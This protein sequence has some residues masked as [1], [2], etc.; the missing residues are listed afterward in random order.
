MQVETGSVKTLQAPSYIPLDRRQIRPNHARHY[1][2]NYPSNHYNPTKRKRDSSSGSNGNAP[3]ARSVSPG[4]A[5]L[6]PWADPVYPYTK[7]IIGLHQEID[8]FY[9][10]IMPTPEEHYMRLGVVRR[11]EEC[12]QKLW[13]AATLHVFGS[14]KTGLYL[15]TSDIDLVLVGRWETLPLRT[16]ERALLDNK[17]ADPATLKVLDKA[18]VPIIKL[19]D[20]I[21]RVRVDVSFNMA[22]GLK[23]VELVK[24]YKKRYP[25]LAKLICVLKQF[26]LQRDLNEVF[27]GGLSSYCLILMVVSFL[28]LHPRQ[29]AASHSANLGVLLIEFFELYG[30]NFNYLR[31]AIRVVGDGSYVTKEQVQV[32]MPPG[33]RPSLLCIEDPLQPGND[34]GKSSY[35]ALQVRQSFD[36]AYGQLT[37]AL[38]GGSGPSILSRI[39]QVDQPTMEYR[40]WIKNT[41]PV[42]AERDGSFSPEPPVVEEKTTLSHELSSAF[43]TPEKDDTTDSSCPSSDVEPEL[44]VEDLTPRPPSADPTT[45]AM[46]IS[47]ANSEVGSRSISRLSGGSSNT[48]PP[49]HHPPSKPAFATP[50]SRQQTWPRRSQGNRADLD[51][52]WRASATGPASDRSSNSGGERDPPARR[53]AERADKDGKW[54]EENGGR[55]PSGAKSKKKNGSLDTSAKKEDISKKSDLRLSSHEVETSSGTSETS[56]RVSEASSRVSEASNRASETSSRVP[57]H[58][59]KVT[60]KAIPTSDQ[61]S[62]LGKKSRKTHSEKSDH[63]P[64]SKG[65][66]SPPV[67]T[68]KGSKP[69]TSSAQSGGDTPSSDGCDK[70]LIGRNVRTPDS[71]TTQNNNNTEPQK[72]EFSQVK[73]SKKKKKKRDHDTNSVASSK[74][75]SSD[76]SPKGDA[77]SHSAKNTASVKNASSRFSGVVGPRIPKR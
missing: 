58:G 16:L 75:L 17:I 41:F 39:I 73:R 50:K 22:N 15:P 11:I 9:Q 31:T 66:E 3:S 56:S 54:R 67:Q 4:A 5:S 25:P 42:Q 36:Y 35:G 24:M 6:P 10:W 47:P 63:R 51:M 2:H 8:D 29:D 48:S 57:D 71:Q 53:N 30:R 59:A 44:T 14:F 21:T 38:R 74:E 70:K 43:M 62:A 46:S 72:T 27:T 1:R 60:D 52:N 77:K 32:D 64:A 13:P 26:L 76:S 68:K 65:S 12:I 23:S 33:H 18:S 20:K 45:S 19:T 49:Y 37:R 55:P 7:G 28:Q 69:S 61:K 34:V 40:G